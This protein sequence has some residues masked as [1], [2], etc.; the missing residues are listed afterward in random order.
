MLLTSLPDMDSGSAEFRDGFLAKWGRENTIIYGRATHARFGP[1]A[2]TFSIRAAWGGTEHCQIGGRRL[3]V[4]DD[5]FLVV[6]DG[7][8]YSTSI[9]A[10]WP[11]ESLSICFRPGL[12]GQTYAAMA[13]RATRPALQLRAVKSRA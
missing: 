3:G 10:P 1:C 7:R 5:N 9:S 12:A 2:H 4:D 6:N 8:V 11:V 13:M